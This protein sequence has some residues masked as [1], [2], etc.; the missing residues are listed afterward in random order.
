MT[1]TEITPLCE[2]RD[3]ILMEAIKLEENIAK[4][5]VKNVHDA[6]FDLGQLN[7]EYHMIQRR[8]WSYYDKPAKKPFWKK[9]FRK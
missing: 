7:F 5:E 3:E 1:I 8:I 6:I 9:L 4:G 2:L